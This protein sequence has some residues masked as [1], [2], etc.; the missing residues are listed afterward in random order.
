MAQAEF[1]PGTEGMIGFTK[2]GQPLTEELTNVWPDTVKG[3]TGQVLSKAKKW[4]AAAEIIHTER[5]LTGEL[6]G[7]GKV[8]TPK[9]LVY[10]YL[11]DK[12]LLGQAWK[13]NQ[14][15]DLTEAPAE[16]P[17]QD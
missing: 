7:A 5:R 6:E 12:R 11:F 8:V 3:K 2:K 1:P 4:E 15:P 17:T 10:Q 9:S 16:S 13:Y 14:L